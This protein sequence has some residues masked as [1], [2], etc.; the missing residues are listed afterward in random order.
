MDTPTDLVLQE[1]KKLRE[2]RGLTV[3][4]LRTSRALLDAL[5]T[6]DAEDARRLI[7]RRLEQLGD[8]QGSRVLRV[9]FS[10]DLPSLLGSTPTPR[11]CDLLGE[12]R[13][14]YA[15]ILGRDVKTLSRWSDKA[16]S[17]L[18]ALLDVDSFQGRV[19]VTAGIQQRRLAGIE[20]LRYDASDTELSEGRTSSYRNL[21]EA[22]SLPCVLYGLPLDWQATSLQFVVTFIEEEPV[23]VWAIAADNLYEIAFGH[24]R[25]AIDI[26]E[27]MVRCRI[28][29]PVHDQVY[30]IWWEW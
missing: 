5:Q 17:E 18:R 13:Q 26:E 21:A 28:D 9:D 2:G 16:L 22:P 27:G 10:L 19:L 1:L 4:R 24:Q 6:D 29:H 3:E 12:R 7:E 15:T 8:G 25:F 20:V 11:D 30:G 14:S 23:Q